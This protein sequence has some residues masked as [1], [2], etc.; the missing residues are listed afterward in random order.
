[1]ENLKFPEL[2]RKLAHQER[3]FAPETIKQLNMARTYKYQSIKNAIAKMD[4]L[5]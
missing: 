5:I 3:N 2:C 4:I 1:M